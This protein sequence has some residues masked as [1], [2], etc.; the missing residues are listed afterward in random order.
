MSAKLWHL[1]VVLSLVAIAAMFAG[2]AEIER[3]KYEMV[4][5]GMDKQTVKEI[6]NVAPTTE[7]GDTILYIPEPGKTPLRVEFEFDANGKLVKKEWVDKEN[8]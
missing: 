7:T 4:K 5:L 1:G 6:M 2:C 3:S 8:L